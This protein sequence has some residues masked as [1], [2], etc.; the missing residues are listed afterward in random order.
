[1]FTVWVYLDTFFT[2]CLIE[3][4]F[5]IYKKL[6]GGSLLELLIGMVELVEAL[7]V[8]VAVLCFATALIASWALKCL[9]YIAYEIVKQLGILTYSLVVDLSKK[10]Y[11]LYKPFS[12]TSDI[13]KKKLAEQNS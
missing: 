7:I 5:E 8:F 2:Y 4:D 6:L 3:I 9:G 10:I 13:E 12:P 1:M 11:S